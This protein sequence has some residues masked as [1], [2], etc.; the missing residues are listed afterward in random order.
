MKNLTLLFV[1]SSCL[2]GFSQVMFTTKD[3]L[4]FTEDSSYARAIVR[5]NNELVF[6]TSKTGV[7]SFNEQTKA[8]K[9]LIPK[10]SGGEFRDLAVTK[11]VLYAM[12]S[13]QNGIIYQYKNQKTAIIFQRKNLFLDDIIF[14]KN[15]LYLLGD[16]IKNHFFIA[17]IGVNKK[18]TDSTI[19]LS[20]ESEEAC[21]AASGT[22]AFGMKNGNYGFVSGGISSARFHQINWRTKV[23]ESVSLPLITGLGAGPFSIFFQ[24]ALKGVIVGGNYLQPLNTKGTACFTIDGGKTW[25]KSE[26]LGYR[27]CVTGN[28]QFLVACGTNG[29]DFS[30]DG[31]ANW[32][33]FDSGNFC[34][35]LLEKNKLYATTNKGYCIVYQLNKKHLNNQY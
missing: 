24:T 33:K 17:Q 14:S 11:K 15:K 20:N 2:N 1:L 22:T 18:H 23:V 10:N 34:A 8:S 6:G 25:Q 9:T 12:I 7:I 16:P 26:T 31:G 4:R 29:I 28:K 30:I 21:Y 5:F 3:T 27:S 13:G 32:E 19:K 35:L